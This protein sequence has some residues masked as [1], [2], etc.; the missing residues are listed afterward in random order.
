MCSFEVPCDRC[1][2]LF[3]LV[4]ALGGPSA[5]YLEVRDR[6]CSKL[7]LECAAR[8]IET[9]HFVVDIFLSPI[10]H[11]ALLPE[12]LGGRNRL[13]GTPIFV[14]FCGRGSSCAD[15]AAVSAGRSSFVS[16]LCGTKLAAGVGAKE[17]TT[18]AAL[19][20]EL[21]GLLQSTSCS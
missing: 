6:K 21:V 15:D 14:I 20:G 13:V 9:L 12:L 10:L 4:L 5:M 1:G 16:C 11:V 19:G 8:T 18:S 17:L 7:C 3:L 2:T